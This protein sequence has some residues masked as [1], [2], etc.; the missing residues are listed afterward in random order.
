[1][2]IDSTKLRLGPCNIYIEEGA[3]PAYVNIGYV[4]EVSIDITP[5]MQALTGGQAGTTPID[6]VVTGV[7]GFVS[8]SAQQIDLLTWRRSLLGVQQ[9]FQ[10][11]TTPANH[12]TEIVT[13]AGQ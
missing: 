13:N 12:R 10:G 5:H 6:E 1:M 7:E 4:D 9:S 3:S 8:F 2:A 11:V